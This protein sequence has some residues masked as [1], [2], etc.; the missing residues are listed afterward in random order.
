MPARTKVF[1]IFTVLSFA[2]G[3][4][5]FVPQVTIPRGLTD[6]ATGLGVGLFIG[7]LVTWASER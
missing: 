7:V 1:L 2:V 3:A 6:F 5:R 4:L